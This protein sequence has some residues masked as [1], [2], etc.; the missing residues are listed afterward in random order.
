MAITASTVFTA[1]QSL[2]DDDGSGRYTETYDLV[3]AINLAIQYLVTVF[4]AA[5]DSKRLQQE[6]LGELLKVLVFTPTFVGTAPNYTAARVN[7]TDHGTYT[8]DNIW[9]IFGIEPNTEHATG[10]PQDYVGGTGKW[11]TKITLLEWNDSID[12]PF[13]PGT[14]ISIPSEFQKFSYIG[15][16]V[17]DG[18]ADDYI[19]IRPG[20]AFNTTNPKVAV[21]V[22]MNPT[23]I[24]SG[25]SVV[26]FPMSLE[27]LLIQKTLQY[28]SMQHGAQAPLGAVTEKEIATLINLMNG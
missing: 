28:I 27:N 8:R 4:T 15:P 23:A 21:W 5:F 25:T 16:V 24:T 18:D 6:Q 1:V 14:L 22:L 2:L 11:A 9:T 12:D 19:L 20:G 3:P 26:E 17:L 10:T 13:A 7:L